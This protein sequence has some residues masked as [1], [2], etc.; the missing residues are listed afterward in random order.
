MR[1]G[2]DIHGTLACRRSDKSVGPSTLFPLLSALMEVWVR[3]GDEVFVLSGPP[4]DVIK[5]EVGALG[6]REGQHFHRLISMVDHLRSSGERMWEDPP[7]SNHWWVDDAAWNTAKGRIAEALNID[8]V[9]DD[10]EMY[11]GAMPKKTTF[12]LVAAS[13]LT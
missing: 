12:V 1:Y 9:V 7:G 11:R 13:L 10:E 4:L 2:I 8:V 3:N 6:L 5:E